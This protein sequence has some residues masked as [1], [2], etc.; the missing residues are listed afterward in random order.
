M[1]RT[2]VFPFIVL[3]GL[4]WAWAHPDQLGGLGTAMH[5]AW[6]GPISEIWNGPILSLWST[7]PPNLRS[8][9]LIGLVVLV[10]VAVLGGPARR[11]R[12]AG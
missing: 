10:L 2:I 1:I 12:M 11:S 4:I 8:L 3:V 7:V 5:A 9:V 6:N